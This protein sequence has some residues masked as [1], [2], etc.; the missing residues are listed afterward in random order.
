MQEGLTCTQRQL[1]TL[2][3]YA[4]FG[5]ALPQ[6][7]YDY[8]ALYDEARAQAVEMLAFTPIIG[9]EEEGMHLLGAQNMRAL[10]IKSLANT[11]LLSDHSYVDRLMRRHGIPYVI[12]KGCACALYYPE[13]SLRVMGD[14]DFLVQ[15]ED[16]ERAK[17]VLLDEGFR[18][19]GENHACHEVFKGNRR[20]SLE[21]HFA[22]SGLPDGRAGELLRGYLRDAVAAGVERQTDLGTLTVPDTFHHGIIILMHTAHHFTGEGIGLRH[23]CDWAVFVNAVRDFPALFEQKLR[24][25]GLWRFAQLI[26]AL[27]TAYLGLP[28]Q[29][30]AQDIDPKLLCALMQDIF[31]GGNFGRKISDRN[32]EVMLMASGENGK[33]RPARNFIASVN[34]NA[35]TKWPVMQRAKVLLPYAWSYYWVRYIRRRIQGKRPSIDIRRMKQGAR[36][37]EALYRSFH[38]FEEEQGD[39]A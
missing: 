13:P 27:S 19:R 10:V 15:P 32:K 6:E 12:L 20:A 21:L 8:G 34:R 24:A 7:T 38:L 37:R 17:Q 26:T 29:Q 16:F 39:T 25:A 30:W 2:L 31:L 1:L 9:S 4:L 11:Q 28:Q 36:E 3:R 18:A 35:Y 5:H 14:V 33:S 23:L 22:P